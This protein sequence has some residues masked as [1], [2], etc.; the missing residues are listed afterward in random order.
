[1]KVIFHQIN[2][3]HHLIYP[4]ENSQSRSNDDEQCEGNHDGGNKSNYLTEIE[5]FETY[6]SSTA[7][8][9]ETS[10][11]LMPFHEWNDI[12]REYTFQPEWTEVFTR[13]IQEMYPLCVLAFNRHRFGK[14]CFLFCEAYC[15][16]EGNDLVTLIVIIAF[17][18]NSGCKYNDE[19]LT[20]ILNSVFGH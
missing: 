13:H 11:F 7:S 10:Y 15:T 12:W 16:I 18:P 8:S 14:R 1:M 19:C 20:I 17:K 3:I 9:K 2:N 5:S 4:T 6:A